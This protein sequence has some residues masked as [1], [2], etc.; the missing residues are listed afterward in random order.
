MVPIYTYNYRVRKRVKEKSWYWCV[1]DKIKGEEF[2][3]Q[4]IIS[5]PEKQERIL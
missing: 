2:Y 5:I 4:A 3:L 1:K